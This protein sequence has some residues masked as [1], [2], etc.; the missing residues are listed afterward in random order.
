MSAQ[1]ASHIQMASQSRFK[2]RIC[3]L[4]IRRALTLLSKR[5]RTI[6]KT[7]AM[8]K[9]VALSLFSLISPAFSLST[10]WVD[11]SC[12]NGNFPFFTVLQDA[13]DIAQR[14]NTRMQSQT[15]TD[16]AVLFDK[17]FKT[18]KTNQNAFTRVNRKIQLHLV[19]QT[20]SYTVSEQ[21]FWV[22]QV[23]AG[24]DGALLEWSKCR[25]TTGL[26]PMFVITAT[27]TPRTS[28]VTQGGHFVQTRTQP[29]Q[30]TFHKG[31]G[32]G[33]IQIVRKTIIKNGKMY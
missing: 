20:R 16:Q 19:S 18:P 9:L 23:Q 31:F 11:Q 2:H 33:L 7:V 21:R 24:Q 28:T 14:G 30:V 22:H 27:T 13:Q 15:D 17:L 25:T 4:S 29:H 26:K 3:L 10:Y 12:T 5:G 32:Q 1:W 6:T 8:G